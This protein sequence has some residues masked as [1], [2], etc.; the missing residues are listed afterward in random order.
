MSDTEGAVDLPLRRVRDWSLWAQPMSVVLLILTVTATAAIAG[1]ASIAGESTTASS[2]G[3]M[4]LLLVLSIGF[5]EVSRRIERLRTRLS[6][7]VFTDLGSVWTFAAVVL[8]PPGHA[9]VLILLMRVH[10]WARQRRAAGSRLYRQTYTAATLIVG[11][12]AASS[13]LSALGSR[14]AGV[15]SVHTALNITAA[16]AVYLLVPT[17]LV[18]VAM[19]LSSRPASLS[20]VVPD[21]DN[22]ALEVA[23]LCLGG[24]FAVAVI[25]QPWLT[26]FVVPPML[27]LQRSALVKQLEEAA[28]I[29]AKTGL[30]NPIAWQRVAQRELARADREHTPVAI[31][32]ADLDHF[33]SVNDTYGHLVGDAVLAEVG[34][35][36]VRELRGYD[37]VGRFGGEEFV[38]VLPEVDLATAVRVAERIRRRVGELHIDPSGV[39]SS[40]LPDTDNVFGTRRLSASIGVASLP[41]H[42]EDLVTLLA[43]ADAALYAAKDAGRDRVVVASRGGSSQ[44]HA[45]S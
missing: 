38:A 10:L 31:L 2:A 12:L 40:H 15:D 13:T 20:A 19:Y 11:A 35:C 33:K 34:S 44:V 25:H 43:A 39:V 17:A 16:L 41:D 32:I 21:W 18:V 1:G 37:S 3:R 24:L 6:T 5:Q 27:L 22:M 8:L 36:L 26:V 9:V 30:L 28:T 4:V 23:T 45:A 14:A 42:G 7:K 29:D